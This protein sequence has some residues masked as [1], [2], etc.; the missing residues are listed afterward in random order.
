MQHPRIVETV[1][2][3]VEGE[4]TASFPT[5][6]LIGGPVAPAQ[7]FEGPES[8]SGGLQYPIQSFQ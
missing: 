1:R 4:G 6:R 5:G 7:R 8:M 3:V 2:R